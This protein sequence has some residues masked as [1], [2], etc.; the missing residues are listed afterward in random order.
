MGDRGFCRRID[1]SGG[2]HQLRQRPGR[3]QHFKAGNVNQYWHFGCDDFASQRFRRGLQHQRVGSTG[4]TDA[5]AQLHVPNGICSERGGQCEWRNYCGIECV[6]YDGQYF[7]IG[8]SDRKRPFDAQSREPKFRQR[9]RRPEQ[10]HERDAG[11]V[12]FECDA[13]LGYGEQ[14]GVSP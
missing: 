14:P 10:E 8:H 9:R 1:A 5:R 11:C 6:K 2:Q 4:H 12:R 3:K 13:I 7:A